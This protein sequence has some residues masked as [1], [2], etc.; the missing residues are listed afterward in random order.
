MKVRCRERESFEGEGE[1]EGEEGGNAGAV[2]QAAKKDDKP[3]RELKK[4]TD[5]RGHACR[6]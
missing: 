5:A 2:A 1:G 3:S 4:P 6:S